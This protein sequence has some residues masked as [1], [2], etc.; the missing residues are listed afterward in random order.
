MLWYFMKAFSSRLPDVLPIRAWLY[1]VQNE[2]EINALML[3]MIEKTRGKWSASGNG[4]DCQGA[5]ETAGDHNLSAVKQE[6]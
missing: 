4:S 1:G 6:G 3:P 2:E 5:T